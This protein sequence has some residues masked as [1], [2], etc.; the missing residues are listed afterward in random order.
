M[1]VQMSM[2]DAPGTLR[3]FE[4][5]YILRADLSEERIAQLNQRLRG[6]IEEASGKVIKLDNWGKRRLAYEIGKQMKGIY[7]VWRY[8]APASLVQELGRQLRMHDAVLRHLTV[9][10]G[11]NVRPD[12][13]AS[14][15]DEERFV[16]ASRVGPDEEEIMT[17]TAPEQ[18]PEGEGLD[19]FDASAAVPEPTPEKDKE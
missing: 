18:V 10:V 9:H 17:G 16:A 4:T 19:E 5:I 13:R 11:S 12:A 3:E 6:L 2:S 14:E 8:L 7:L 1:Q 15:M